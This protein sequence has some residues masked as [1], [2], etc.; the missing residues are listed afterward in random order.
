[1]RVLQQHLDH[2]ECFWPLHASRQIARRVIPIAIEQGQ[3][4]GRNSRLTTIDQG[5][6]LD[7]VSQLP[8]NYHTA[9]QAPSLR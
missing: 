2:Y 6:L 1:M 3:N 8:S 4:P 9:M 7:L 5:I